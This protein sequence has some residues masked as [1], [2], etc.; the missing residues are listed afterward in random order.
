MYII[1][2]SLEIKT[3]IAKSTEIFL[4]K[5]I[6]DKCLFAFMICGLSLLKLICNMKLS[7]FIIKCSAA[8]KMHKC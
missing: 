1:F 6:T 3:F 7:A 8:F 5:L 2:F 4:L